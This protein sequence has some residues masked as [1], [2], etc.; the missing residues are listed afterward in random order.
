[1]LF[2]HRTSDFGLQLLFILFG[3]S[4]LF[5]QQQQ[6]TVKLPPTPAEPAQIKRIEDL[7]LKATSF[8]FVRLKYSVNPENPGHAGNERWSIDYPDSDRRF[9]AWF[10]KKTGIK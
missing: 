1:M 5:A 7:K 10:E 3:A 2:H 8:T 4:V 9:S 6:L